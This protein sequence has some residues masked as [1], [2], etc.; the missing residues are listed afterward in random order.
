RSSTAVPEVTT[1]GASRPI[2]CT[3]STP[4]ACAGG[5]CSTGTSTSGFADCN[6]NKQTDGCEINTNTNASNCGG[7]G[8]VC[9]SN[10]IPTTSCASGS[11]NGACASGYADCNSN[12]LTDG[13]E[14]ST[15]TDANNCGA[16][17]TQCH[18]NATNTANSC[19]TTCGN[20]TRCNDNN[21]CTV[22]SCSSGACGHVNG[23][24]GGTCRAAAGTCD[25]AEVCPAVTYEKTLTISGSQ[26]SATLTNFPVLVRTTD[27]D[28][29]NHAASDGSDIYFTSN[30]TT[31]LD[32]E[33]ERYD[34]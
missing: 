18:T 30:H 7:C 5:A 21:A 34:S 17:G 19:G 32:Y 3:S 1:G 12:K 9:S 23:N 28:L 6:G 15:N 22:D 10:H 20:V 24:S 16:C 13:C 26:V 14:T 25:V 8:T 2:S 27:T 33:I 29:K 31:V 4:P 11:C